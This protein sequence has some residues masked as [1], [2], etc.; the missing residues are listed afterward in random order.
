MDFPFA[1][2]PCDHRDQTASWPITL[3]SKTVNGSGC[4]P[5]T[6]TASADVGTAGRRRDEL[7]RNGFRARERRHGLPLRGENLLNSAINSAG[8]PAHRKSGR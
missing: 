2:L 1:G 7:H 5:G 8:W 4:P 6:A 3:D